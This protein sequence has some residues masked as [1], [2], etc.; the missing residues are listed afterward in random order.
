[1]RI[2]FQ[3]LEL[4][5]RAYL[6]QLRAY[7]TTRTLPAFTNINPEDYLLSFDSPLV[8]DAHE[9]RVTQLFF[10]ALIYEGRRVLVVAGRYD[11]FRTFLQQIRPDL[12]QHFYYVTDYRDILGLRQ[13]DVLTVL[14]IGTW[15]E[16]PVLFTPEIRARLEMLDPTLRRIYRDNMGRYQMGHYQTGRWLTD[17]LLDRYFAKRKQPIIVEIMIPCTVSP[18]SPEQKKKEKAGRYKRAYP[19]I[20]GEVRW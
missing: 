10:H 5:R 7:L 2:P 9:L 12:H 17:A 1:M 19:P 8:L 3:S 4:E 20:S 16:S 18:L 14:L 13:E 11:Q 15:W 6:E